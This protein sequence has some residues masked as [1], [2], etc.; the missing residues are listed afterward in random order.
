[1]EKQGIH[2][3]YPEETKEKIISTM[4]IPVRWE[5]LDINGHVNYSNYL[6]YYSEARIHTIGEELFNTLRAEGIGPVIYKAE[7][8]FIKELFY[9][10]TVHIVTWLDRSISP[11]RVSIRQNMYSLNHHMLI[12]SALFYAI[13]M[14]L[15][16]RRPVRPPKEL[17]EKY[18]LKIS[19][20]RH[21]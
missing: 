16:N 10:D 7:L 15:E 11:T 3:L 14:K 4:E 12:S 9:P 17:I 21:E 13:F 2:Q 6:N 18:N 1:M 8:D 5:E 19:R 20:D